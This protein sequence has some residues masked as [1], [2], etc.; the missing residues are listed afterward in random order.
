MID[1][2]FCVDDH[3]HLFT[4]V[5]NYGG[6]FIG[7]GINMSYKGGVID[8]YDFCEIDKWNLKAL[9]RVLEDTGIVMREAR[10]LWCLPGQSVQNFGL[11]DIMNDQDCINMAGAVAVGHEELSIY[12]D[13]ANN[14]PGYTNDDVFQFPSPHRPTIVTQTEEFLRKPREKRQLNFDTDFQF[15]SDGSDFEEEI[16]DSDYDL[17]ERDDDLY[18]DCIE[19][20]E[21]IKGKKSAEEFELDESDKDLELPEFEDEQVKFKFNN[22]TLVDMANPQFKVGQTFFSVELLRKA[23]REYNYRE[24]V[25]ISMP[26]NDKNRIAAR[27]ADCIWYLWASWDS[28]SKCF[29][30]KRHEPEHTYERVWKVRGFTYKFIAEKYIDYFRADEGMNIKNLARVV[31]KEWNMTPSGLS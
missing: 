13:H 25:N 22:F 8:L 24:R 23:I 19:D 15:D 3:E 30:I 9:E 21:D 26:T 17:Y 16:V 12:V 1:N 14:I 2:Y 29:L 11:A 10:V 5:V 28:R 18:V 6:T 4:V 20:D 27:C 7:S 31:Q